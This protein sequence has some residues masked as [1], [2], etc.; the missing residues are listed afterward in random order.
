MIYIQMNKQ[1]REQ[2]IIDIR[3]KGDDYLDYDWSDSIKEDFLAVLAILGY[4]EVESY[5]SGFSSQGD[6]ASFKAMYI[7]AKG[8]V[9]TMKGYAPQDEELHRIATE[10]FNI[11]KRCKFDLGSNI[12]ISSSNYCHEMTMSNL[13]WSDRDLVSEDVVDSHDEE[14]LELHRDL[15]RWYYKKLNESYDYLMSDEAIAEHLIASEREF[16]HE[17][18]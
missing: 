7:Y 2:A 11:Q 10:L 4:Y 5:F 1:Q 18:S 12:D 16:E 17:D 13:N 9:K 14:T 6:G 8:S 3:D 15:A